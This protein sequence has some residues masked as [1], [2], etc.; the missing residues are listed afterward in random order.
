MHKD[1]VKKE[2]TKVKYE[3]IQKIRNREQSFLY[4]THPLNPIHIAIKFQGYSVWLPT[5]D[6]YKDSLNFNQREVTQ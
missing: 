2:L 3:V 5:Y 6:M 4:V 1:S